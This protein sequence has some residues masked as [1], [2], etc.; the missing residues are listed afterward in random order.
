MGNPTKPSVRSVSGT[1]DALALE[2]RFLDPTPEQSVG[3]PERLEEASRRRRCRA[4]RKH[5]DL[6]I[7]YRLGRRPSRHDPRDDGPP[8]V[9][10]EAVDALF[11]SMAVAL[12]SKVTRRLGLVTRLMQLSSKGLASASL[13]PCL[14]GMGTDSELNGSLRPHCASHISM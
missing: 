14:C 5:P 4:I 3:E 9:A 7:H 8:L 13:V 2:R 6:A 1:P 12:R 11:S 10:R